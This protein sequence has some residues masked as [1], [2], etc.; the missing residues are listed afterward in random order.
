[1]NSK[2]PEFSWNRVAI[3]GHD[4]CWNW[5]GGINSHG[6]GLCQY[7]GKARNASRA[8]YMEINGGPPDG[9]VVCHTCD[10]RLCC[11]PAH[12]VAATQ[13]DN[14]R[15]CVAKSRQNLR[16]GKDHHRSN[17]KLTPELVK[18][19]RDLY[20]SG[21]ESQSSIGRRLGLH[22]SVVSRAIRGHSWGHVE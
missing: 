18:E 19:C 2:R 3:G 13:G 4:E 21:K 15:D 10:N 8:A 11:N 12:L 20:F 7:N 22:S 1:M 9:W 14:V 16:S 5:K 17:A 6:Y